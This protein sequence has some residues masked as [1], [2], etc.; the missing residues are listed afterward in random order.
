MLLHLIL[1]AFFGV[2]LPWMKGLE[3]LDPPM[4]CGYACLGA[5]FAGPSAGQA[6]TG[7]GPRRDGTPTTRPQSWRE[8][9]GRIIRAMVYGETLIAVFLAAGILTVNFRHAGHWWLPQLDTLAA[10]ALLG[11]AASA[12]VVVTVAWLSLR[13]SE[14][15]ARFGMR[16]LL[17]VMLLA[18]YY[19]SL[20]IAEYALPG[21]LFCSLAALGFFYL[22]RREVVPQ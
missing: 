17:L 14:R 20:R 19:E 22:L 1:I 16:F 4:I 2:Y 8:A 13:Y 3:F 15:A 7:G 6:F 18:Y 21:T 5:L 10:S 11:A 12:L 9:V